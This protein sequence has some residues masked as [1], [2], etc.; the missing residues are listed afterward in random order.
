MA[1]RNRT[2]IEDKNAIYH[3]IVK[4]LEGINI[5]A[6]DG[7]RNKFLQFLQKMINIHRV[8]LFSYVL[9]DTHFHLLLRTEEANLSQA[10]QFLNSSYAHW[11]NYK[12]IRKG[13]LFQDRYKS[14]L[15]LS[16]L[17]L[18]NVASYI[19]LNPVE[20]EIVNSPEEYRWSSFRYF[21]SASSPSPSHPSHLPNNSPPAW[22]KVEEFLKF[23][24]TNAYGFVHFVKESMGKKDIEES[25]QEISQSKSR[26]PKNID[27]IIDKINLQFGDIKTNK[28]LRNLLVYLLVKKGYRIKEISNFLNLS[29]QAVIKIGKKTEKNLATDSIY[30]FWL[31]I[32]KSRILS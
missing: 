4:G 13:H 5:F 26:F 8:I 22:L 31:E 25:L 7:D 1:R 14:H 15:I 10:M 21:S 2:D 28:N 24:N 19:S 9:M 11:F 6:D 16:P 18:Y 29:K 27:N 23:C 17:Y 3:I 32:I 30:S 20:A 12:H